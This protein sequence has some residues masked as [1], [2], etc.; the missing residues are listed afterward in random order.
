MPEPRIATPTLAVVM[1]VKD[2]AD[3]VARAVERVLS[4][5]FRDIEFV[6]VDD[7]ATDDTPAILDRYAAADRRM[8]VIHLANEALGPA[9][10]TAICSTTARL[11]CPATC[12]RRESAGTIRGA[13]TI[14]AGQSCCNSL[15]HVGRVCA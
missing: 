7:A 2:S 5:S 1:T 15:R 13:G 4:Q 14:H 12:R 6:V 11:H 9:F 10:N 8:R 3:C